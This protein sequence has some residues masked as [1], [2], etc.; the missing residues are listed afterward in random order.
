VTSERATA[1]RYCAPIALAAVGVDRHAP[2]TDDAVAA[3][4]GPPG[5]FG[6][7]ADVTI[8]HNPN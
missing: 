7:M 1:R 2:F 8:Y 6:V 4:L 3:D 5:N